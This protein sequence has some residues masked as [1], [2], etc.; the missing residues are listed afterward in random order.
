LANTFWLGKTERKGRR[1]GKR[2]L[3]SESRSGILMSNWKE[4][5]PLATEK[6]ATP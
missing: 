3:A 6:P 2:N 5:L 4:I 1:A